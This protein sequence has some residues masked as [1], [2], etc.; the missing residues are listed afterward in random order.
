MNNLTGKLLGGK[1]KLPLRLVLV[2][3]FVLQICLA[4][5]L[6]GWLSFRNGQESVSELAAQLQSEISDRI[7]EKTNNYLNTPRIINQISASEINAKRLNLDNK[8]EL[9]RHFTYMQ[10]IFKNINHVGLGTQTGEY[11]AVRR[12]L[13]RNEF[14]LLEG[15]QTALGGKLLTYSLD[16]RGDR[17]KIIHTKASYDPRS[18]PWYQDGIVDGKPR[19]SRIYQYFQVTTLGIS[20]SYPINRNGIL[21]GVLATD[22]DLGEISNFLRSL[23]IG[24]TGRTFLMERNGNIIA[25]STNEK[26]FVIEAGKTR[27]IKALESKDPLVS[28]TAAYLINKYG[29]LSQLSPFSEQ[30]STP[31]SQVS[32]CN[33]ASQAICSRTEVK[34]AVFDITGVRQFLRVTA[35]KNDEGVDWLLVVISPEA[36]FMDRINNNTNLTI[37]LCFIALMAAIAIGLLTAHWISQPILRLGKASSAIANFSTSLEVN[38]HPPVAESNVIVELETLANSFNQMA[39]RLRDSFTDL[40][41]ANEE[42]EQRVTERTAALSQANET[43]HR[44]ATLDGL[45][46]VANR[47]RLDEYLEQVWQESLQSPQPLAMILCDVD[48]FKLFNDTYGHQ[49]GDDCLQ[50]VA[51]TI[52][53]S[54]KRSDDLVARYGGEEFAVILP[55]CDLQNAVII[56]ERMRTAIAHLQISHISSYVKA[57]VTLSLGIAVVIPTKE[58]TPQALIAKADGALYAAKARGRDRVEISE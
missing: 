2:V 5:G 33:L 23:R 20:H 45:T 13:I 36:D 35:L 55:N 44:L 51:Q 32:V 38:S 52:S 16:E 24:R 7:S 49:M 42:L 28:G 9:I 3:P 43:L 39:Q 22:F 57:Y 26:L 19:W 37:F 53:L 18:R 14:E 34:T 15:D 17:K 1:K 50:Q 6:T 58:V 31:P 41:R 25:S 10:R 12:K 11:L 4:V 56:A 54:V 40:K 30:L 48:C 47:R 27:Q 8:T 29:N 21:Y 46:Q